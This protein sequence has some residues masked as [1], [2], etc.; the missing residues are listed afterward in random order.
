MA[1][2]ATIRLATN[3][4]GA[5]GGHQARTTSG[6]PISWNANRRPFLSRLICL[7]PQN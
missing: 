2:L 4:W 1:A 7:W 5:R 3:R 6:Y